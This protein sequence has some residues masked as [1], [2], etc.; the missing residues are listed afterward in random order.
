[1][2]K[3]KQSGETRKKMGLFFGGI[4][5]LIVIALLIVNI[6]G[7]AEMKAY[8][9]SEYAEA[10]ENYTKHKNQDSCYSQYNQKTGRFEK[11]YNC[12]DCKT[13]KEYKTKSEYMESVESKIYAPR[14]LEVGGIAIGAVAILWCVLYWNNRNNE[15]A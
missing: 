6:S 10:Y 15:H 14:Y 11:V 4:I 12:L 8:Y 13:I 5:I 2:E 7:I 9:E 3:K 1:M